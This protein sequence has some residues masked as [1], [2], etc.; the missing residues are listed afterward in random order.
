[1]RIGITCCKDC[2]ERYDY[3]H[4]HC[5]K[6]K[7]EKAEWEKTKAEIRKKVEIEQGVT[8]ESITNMM[9]VKQKKRKQV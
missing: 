2:T 8:F 4:A 1:M 9:R 7:S 6:Y 3:C 5:E